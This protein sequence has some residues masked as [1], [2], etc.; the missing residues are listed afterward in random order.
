M[1]TKQKNVK[2][3][4]FERMTVKELRAI[5]LELPEISGAHGMNKPELISQIKQAKGIEEV[6]TNPKDAS[7]RDIKLKIKSFKEKRAE[8]LAGDDSRMATRF[9]RTISRLKKKTRQRA[10]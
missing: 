6:K 2:E 10:A 1:G 3:K 9:R 8:A 5:A 7:V 4:P